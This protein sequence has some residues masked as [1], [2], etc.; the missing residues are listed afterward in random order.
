MDV[1]RYT[2][3][4]EGL[5]PC[6]AT[7]G[8]FDG[9]HRG[10]QYLVRQV[11]ETA[12]NRGIASTVITFDRHPRQVVQPAFVPEL[13]TTLND[14]LSLLS[15][16]GVDRVVVLPFDQEMAALTAHEFMQQV[17]SRL[18]VQQLIIGYD[19][20]FGH[21]QPTDLGREEGFDHYVACGREL[22]ITVT[23][24]SEVSFLVEGHSVS[25]SLVRSYIKSGQMEQAH[26]CL[27]RPYSLTGHVVAGYQEGRKLG[28]PTANLSSDSVATLIPAPGVYAVEVQTGHDTTLWR[29]MMNI[30]TR[31]TFDGHRQTL[32]VHLFNFSGNL[33]GQPLTVAFHQRVRGEQR[34]SSPEALAAQL[35]NDQQTIIELFQKEETP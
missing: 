7:I 9:V 10:H 5:S 2:T 19:H 11:V 14:K 20:R 22:G 18:Q 15:Q 6:V 21:R 32:E 26:D 30:G 1:I 33:Y 23:R 4:A 8:F 13:L 28:F 34:F 24:A 17:L 31:P 25:S 35:R 12:W 16:T 29:G 27:S 3:S